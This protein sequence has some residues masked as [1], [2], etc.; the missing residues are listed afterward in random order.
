MPAPLLVSHALRHP[1]HDGSSSWPLKHGRSAF[2]GSYP[3]SRRSRRNLSSLLGRRNVGLCRLLIFW[4]GLQ[5]VLGHGDGDA[6]RA[7]VDLDLAPVDGHGMLPN[8]KEPTDI[9]HR[10][11][12]PAA[13]GDDQ[14]IHRA[15]RFAVFAVGF[16]VDDVAGMGGIGERS[17]LGGKRLCR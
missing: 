9:D 5:L 14:V 1:L 17:M 8:A 6:I 12:D 4:S 3:L 16:L 10:R 7:G 15:N 2:S 13:G 11:I